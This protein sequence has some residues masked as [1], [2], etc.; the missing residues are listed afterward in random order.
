MD[1]RTSS[2]PIV[3]T[4]AKHPLISLLPAAGSSSTALLEAFLEFVATQNLTLYP[5]QEEAVLAL[6]EGH[7]VILNTPT[8]SGKSLVAVAMH[9]ASI[10]AG[11]RSYYTCPIKALVNE[12][13]LAMCRDFG[14]E[15]VGMVTGDA[16]VNGA[17]PII[18]CTAEI[19]SNI[20]LREGEKALVDDVIMDEF[21]YYSDRERG[22]AWQ[23]PLL[24]L[25]QAR[26]MLMSA[27]LGDVSQ[28]EKGLTAL[29]QRPTTVV[30]S[31]DRPVPLIFSYREDPLHQT[32]QEL[33]TS[34]KAPV[35]LVSFTQ[36]ECADSAQSLMSVD[37]CSREEKQAISSFLVDLG[38]KF[39]SPYGKELLRTLKHG[40]GIHHAGLLPKYRYAVERLAQNGLLKVICGTDT[41]GVGVN[42]PIRTVLFSKLC[43][44]DGE[45][46]T[47]LSVRDFHQIAGRAGRKGFDVEGLVV[48]QAP[49]HVIENMRLEAK[50]GGDAK[51][52]RKITR[53][54]PPERGFVMWSK[55]TFEKLIASEPEPLQSRFSISHGMILNV[56]S[57]DGDGCG[58]MRQ[59]IRDNHESAIQK[60]RQRSRAFKL[61]RSLIDRRIIEFVEKHGQRRK[62]LRVNVDLQEDFSIHHA[63]ALYLMDTVNKLD[64]YTDSYALDV[65][66]LAE[67]IVENP[68]NILRRQLDIIKRDKV[69]AMK[70][71]GIPYDERMAELEDLEYPKPNRDFIYA[72]FN[73]FVANHPWI[74]QENVRPKSVA[75]DMYEQCMTF[76]EYVREYD[77]QRSEGLLLRYVSEVYKVLTQTVPE[78]AKDGEFQEIIEYFGVMV[79]QVDSTLLDEWEKLKHPDGATAAQSA[80]DAAAL[81]AELGRMGDTDITRNR[82]EFFAAIRN[83][84]F[85]YVKALAGRRIS[86]ICEAA[87]DV[88]TGTM[89]NEAAV[90]QT[91]DTYAQ[92]HQGPLTDR[93]ARGPTHFV[94]NSNDAQNLVVYQ[95]LL[96]ADGHNDWGLVF[97]VDVTASREAGVVR[98]RL[99]SIGPIDSTWAGP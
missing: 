42:V 35:Y 23:V 80:A 67:A 60:D 7:N 55:E 6:F 91:L 47:L 37:L 15:N 25:P 5:A 50:A 22:V 61:F 53:K 85:Q 38:I 45:K 70:A 51:K 30:R 20:A 62:A 17:A 14:P 27:T 32:V 84:A 76:A 16:S 78:Q 44:F 97:H 95:T 48:A 19:L 8:G 92:E 58:A 75:R 57:R 28:F 34:G 24:T 54:K 26:F 81:A 41:L 36:R 72:T 77:L 2:E 49:E 1:K 71:E 69:N 21:H 64:P 99:A 98:L 39:A 46:T 87:R 82:R 43:K 63:M 11:R 88:D 83:E 12:K 40:I 56:L 79:R 73:E 90:K 89:W 93:Q 52:L 10:A 9:F 4:V 74:G 29:N 59:L 86:W 96:D 65:L 33:A 13:F 68:E 18:C 66:T 94:I 3:L 31:Y